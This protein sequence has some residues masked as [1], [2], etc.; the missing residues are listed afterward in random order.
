[1]RFARKFTSLA[2]TFLAAIVL[3]ACGAAGDSPTPA[4]DRAAKP[5]ENSPKPSQRPKLAM[6]KAEISKLPKIVIGKRSGPPPRKLVVNDLRKG[7]GAAVT[8]KDAVLVNYFSVRYGEALRRRHGGEFGET[9]F[10]LNEVV[11]GWELGLPGMKV[12]GRREL[13][14]PPRLAYSGTGTLIYVIDLLAVER[15]GAASF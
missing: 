15:G 14:V 13:I 5:V 8:S 6:S 10:G 3:A 12:G 7:S 11:K 4:A 9:R 1:M 2:G